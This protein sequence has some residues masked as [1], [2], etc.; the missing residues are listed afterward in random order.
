M[1][2]PFRTKVAMDEVNKR[3]DCGQ[4]DWVF[5]VLKKVGVLARA[6]GY[7]VR[8]TVPPCGSMLKR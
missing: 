8:E 1:F 6:M 5:P 3:S 7:L 4:L 2:H